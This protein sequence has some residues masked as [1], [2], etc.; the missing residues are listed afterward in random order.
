M[1][2]NKNKSFWAAVIVLALESYDYVIFLFLARGAH[3][4]FLGH[5]L[6]PILFLLNVILGFTARPIGGLLF[7]VLADKWGRKPLLMST[8]VLM[9][10][11]TLVIGLVPF[12]K[13]FIATNAAFILI[14]FKAL[15]GAIFGSDF[16]ITNTYLSEIASKGERGFYCSF[17][18]V[19]QE[20]GTLLA[21]F[22]SLGFVL[23]PDS[24]FINEQGWRIPFIS[25][26]LSMFLGI[27]LRYGLLESP[28]YLLL[29]S[30][31]IAHSNPLTNLFKKYRIQVLK[32]FL[33]I[34]VIGINFYFFRVYILNQANVL[35]NIK[36]ELILILSSLAC[37]ANMFTAALGGYLSDLVGRKP[38]L[39]S[40]AMGILLFSWPTL[41]LVNHP[42][43]VHMVFIR[44]LVGQLIMALFAGLYSGAISSYMAEL[45]G[46][47]VRNT[48]AALTYNLAISLISGVMP[49]LN[50]YLF[51]GRSMLNVAG[52]FLTFF[53]LVALFTVGK[54]MDETY[55]KVLEP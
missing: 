25:G 36:V 37:I 15:Q 40:G 2:L 35:L 22:V 27:H 32:M 28:N 30:K 34:P 1:K 17:S 44:M 45:F 33:I 49:L 31:G 21:I 5:E 47:K 19:A 23:V 54:A 14:V 55:S 26:S 16:I 46:T 12:S 7:G 11:F 24:I 6:D 48:G 9:G 41:V 3:W 18:H 8:T 10:I 43:E 39:I 42:G 29:K 20:I 13:G 51:Q 38:I 4:I 53:A 52:A 50:L